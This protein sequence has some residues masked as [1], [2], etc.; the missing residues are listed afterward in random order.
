[1]L[2]LSGEITN[3][4]LYSIRTASKVGSVD[5]PIINPANLHIDAFL[6]QT[7]IGDQLILLDNEIRELSRKGFIID[8][9][10]KLSGAD[11]LVRLKPVIDL[12]FKLIGKKVISGSRTIGKVEDFV[13]ETKSLYIQQLKVTSLLGKLIESDKKIIGR[14]QIIEINDQAIFVSGPEEKASYSIFNKKSL[15]NSAE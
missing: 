15:P 10:N 4:D 2:V 1:M 5:L 11:D 7:I 8:D 3:K 6:C 14:D 9:V 13:I 12:N